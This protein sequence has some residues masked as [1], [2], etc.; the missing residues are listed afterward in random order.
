MPEENLICVW[1]TVVIIQVILLNVGPKN[2]NHKIKVQRL[3]RISKKLKA[4]ASNS[5]FFSPIIYGDVF[6]K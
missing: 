6:N 2:K 3:I 1:D 5:D 4:P